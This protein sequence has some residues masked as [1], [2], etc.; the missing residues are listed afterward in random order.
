MTVHLTLRRVSKSEWQ[1]FAPKGHSIGP[2]YRGDKFQAVEWARAYVSAWP[3]WK[4]IVE[5]E[6]N[7][8]KDRL[9]EQ[10]VRDPEV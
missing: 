3:N 8:K 7:E 1:I 4:I 2:R 6:T 10:A 5:G 9:S